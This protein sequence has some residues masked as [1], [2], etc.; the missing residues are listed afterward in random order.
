MHLNDLSYIF[1][2]FKELI[3]NLL[4]F[5]FIVKT[6]MEYPKFHLMH[7]SEKVMESKLKLSHILKNS[8]RNL[9]IGYF[10]IFLNNF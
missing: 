3:T 4:F 7:I 10:N 6:V 9:G 1:E 8:Y 5:L 2:I